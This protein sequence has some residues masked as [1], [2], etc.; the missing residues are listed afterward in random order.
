M[1]PVTVANYASAYQ[2]TAYYPQPVYASGPHPTD[3]DATIGLDAGGAYTF[4]LPPYDNQQP[5]A[6]TVS[7]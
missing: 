6:Y 5:P 1:P 7:K 4:Q 2:N 3:F